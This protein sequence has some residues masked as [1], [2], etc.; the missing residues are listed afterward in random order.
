M[1]CLNVYLSHR[2]ELS[3]LKSADSVLC[4]DK[5]VLHSSK[6]FEVLRPLRSVGGGLYIAHTLVGVL[7]ILNIPYI[8]SNCEYA[9]CFNFTFKCVS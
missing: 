8:H 1:G 3:Q 6:R 5:K 2:L 4:S 9:V 7:S